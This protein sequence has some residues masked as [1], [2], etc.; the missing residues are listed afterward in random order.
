MISQER[1]VNSF[2]DLVRIDSPSDEEEEMA[3]HLMPRLRN[4]GFQVDRDAHGNV[5]ASEEG[6]N[7]LLLSAHMDT[8]DPGRGIKPMVD[9]DTLR[10]DGIVTVGLD[11][12]K[13]VSERSCTFFVDCVA[14]PGQ[15][16][17]PTSQCL[18]TCIRLRRRF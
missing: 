10:S 6:S 17:V 9:G 2:F 3:Q 14:G 4:L 13:C 11:V 8:V 15:L 18:F 16:I 1:L 12:R 5:I 7:P